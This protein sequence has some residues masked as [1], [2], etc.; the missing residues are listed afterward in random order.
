M[1]ELKNTSIDPTKGRWIATR[2]TSDPVVHE[3]LGGGIG[4]N[5]QG[6]SLIKVPP[7]IENPLGKYYLYFAD[8]K[9]KYIR[10]AYAE[11]LIG[12][13]YIHAPGTLHL[14]DSLFPEEISEEDLS[15]VPVPKDK[16]KYPHGLLFERTE[17]HIASPDVHVDSDDQTIVMYFHGLERDGQQ[18]TRCATSEDGLVFETRPPIL[19]T[20]YFRVL[21]RNENYLATTMRGRFYTSDSWF[22]PF[23]RESQFFNSD[24]RH[25]ALLACDNTLFVFWTQVGETPEHIKVS[26]FDLSLGLKNMEQHDMG[27]VLKPEMSWEGAEEPLEPSV[28]SV[29]YGLKNQLRDPT[30]FVE[31]DEVF[32]LYAGGGESAIGI[33]QLHFENT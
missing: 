27:A 10:L 29:A 2:L 23:K 28:R 25:M 20:S 15:K 7:W 12:P 14:K 24:C 19:A 33:A 17:T 4:V 3:G 21:P 16:S 6:P 18:M 9:G 30:I 31:D 8:H 32:L 11:S 5:I 1:L 22:G 13:W 26:W